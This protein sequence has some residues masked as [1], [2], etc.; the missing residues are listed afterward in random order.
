M[1]NV[2]LILTALFAFCGSISAQ[3]THWPDF[4]YYNYQLNRP[5][6]AIIQ[7]NGTTISWDENWENLE[8]AAFVNSECR[9]HAFM[10]G[11]GMNYNDEYPVVELPIYYNDT[12]EEVTF[13]LYDHAQ[14]I[15]YEICNVSFSGEES[16]VLT[17]REYVEGYLDGI[18]N[19]ICLNFTTPSFN[20]LELANDDSEKEVG[21]KNA[22][23]I[24]TLVGE[25]E[26]VTTNVKLVG[27][28]LLKDGYF[29]TICLPFDMTIGEGGI[30]GD[31][32]VMELDTEKDK[33]E[34]DTGFDGGTLY[35][36]FREISETMEA[37]KPYLIK[38]ERNEGD[39]I[40]DPIFYDVSVQNINPTSADCAVTSEDGTVTFKGTFSTLKINDEDNTMLCLGDENKLFYPYPEGENTTTIGAFRAYFQLN[41]GITVAKMS[42][43]RLFFGDSD[44]SGIEDVHRSTFN[45]QRDHVW[46]SL[47]GRRLL[48]KPAKK[49]IYVREGRKVV[50]K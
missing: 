46:Y 48:G 19:S 36:N 41:G 45:V 17:G 14:E 30:F 18:E 35:L 1:K 12:G 16:S 25:N 50:V 26:S 29:S 10:I 11:E 27:R 47:D 23:L 31:A 43:A 33:Y 3:D 5:F 15:I 7:I 8:V 34:H 13:M 42:E 4:N 20:G 9:G 37:G 2:L 40:L 21:K 44:A 49:G 28:T 32:T 6:V 24:S 38:W 22:D 39:P